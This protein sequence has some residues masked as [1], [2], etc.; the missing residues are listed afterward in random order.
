MI[1]NYQND[2]KQMYLPFFQME[3]MVVC[4]P[5]LPPSDKGVDENVDIMLEGWEYNENITQRFMNN[6]ELYVL[7]LA[8]CN[9]SLYV[10]TD[11]AEYPSDRNLRVYAKL[12]AP[13]SE[14]SLIYE[15]HI[16]NNIDM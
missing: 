10:R 6:G 5:F 12:Q 7:G 2:W 14:W 3:C 1:N 16:D 4:E 9:W 11:K 13:I 8:N 15:G